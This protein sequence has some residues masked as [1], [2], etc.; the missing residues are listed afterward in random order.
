MKTSIKKISSG[1]FLLLGG[2]L[3]YP[4]LFE[5]VPFKG[6]PKNN[7][8]FGIVV[9]VPKKDKT[10]VDFIQNEIN[11]MAA[12]K[13]KLKKL[14]QADCCF[15]DGDEKANEAYHG[16]MV[17]SLYSYP[18]DKKVK[19]GQPQVFNPAKQELKK[20][21]SGTP[22]SGCYGNVIFD[23]YVPG[24]WKKVS[25]GLHVVQ[26]IEDGEVI[27]FKTD[28]SEL[29]EIPAKNIDGEEEEEEDEVDL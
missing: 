14:P 3:A 2:R 17:L 13:L 16:H 25:G 1:Q 21:D 9:L 28:T 8:R 4:E 10:T 6:D 29:P 27:G 20:G 12:D 7:P 15:T 22:Y 26:F 5:A 18:S 11:T 23:L 19:G 24:S